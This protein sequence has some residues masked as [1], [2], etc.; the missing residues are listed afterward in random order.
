VVAVAVVAVAVAVVAVCD[1]QPDTCR[2]SS[3]CRQ[4]YPGCM[5]GSPADVFEKQD[6]YTAAYK[7]EYNLCS[8]DIPSLATFRLV[9]FIAQAVDLFVNA[10]DCPGRNAVV[11]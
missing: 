10:V 6:E 2:Q 3:G 4:D 7:N 11:H 1:S 9:G 8:A 5:E